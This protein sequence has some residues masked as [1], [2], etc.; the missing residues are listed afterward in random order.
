MATA[1]APLQ[2]RIKSRPRAATP[3]PMPTA[4]LSFTLIPLAQ[5]IRNPD[6]PRTEFDPEALEQLRAS[7]KTH[8]QLQ[9][10]G[11]Q[12]TSQDAQ[13]GSSIYMIVFGERRWRAMEQA[14]EADGFTHLKCRIFPEDKTPADILEIQLAENGHRRDLNPIEEAK[15]FHRLMELREWLQADLAGAIGV[16][17]SR[18]SKAIALLRLPPSV[19]ELVARGELTASNAYYLKD[20]PPRQ[21]VEVAE[22]AAKEHWKRTQIMGAARARGAPVEPDDETSE[23]NSFGYSPGILSIIG[24][25]GQPTAQT[26]PADYLVKCNACGYTKLRSVPGPC[27]ESHEAGWS[28]AEPSIEDGDE[29]MEEEGPSFVCS[30]CSTVRPVHAGHPCPDCRCPTFRLRNIESDA[31]TDYEKAL[32]LLGE[33]DDPGMV[34]EPPAVA[35]PAPAVI[36]QAAA[37]AVA[38]AVA[39]AIRPTAPPIEAPKAKP[40]PE[41]MVF[42]FEAP[43]GVEIVATPNPRRMAWTLR[44][45]LDAVEWVATQLREELRAEARADLAAGRV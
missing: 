24:S 9:P 4:D 15:A 1:T 10:I 26:P 23:P 30:G 35:K 44:E 3:P 31:L 6:Q 2:S 7:L 18:I 29:E 40:K 45:R 42:R 34:D 12:R 17:Q 5:I 27:P 19:Q 38:L 36:H 16:T 20:L 33:S 21:A 41:Q 22:V 43:N 11:V 8:G 25:E 28:Y 14:D 37:L 13:D 39:P 32:V